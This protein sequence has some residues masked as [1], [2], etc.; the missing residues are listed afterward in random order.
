M[1]WL[2]DT[3]GLHA[4]ALQLRGKRSEILASNIA[5]AD[6]PGYKA[7][8][9]DFNTALAAA[10]SG[11]AGNALR[12]TDDQ[13]MSIAD[14]ARLALHYRIPTQDSSNGNTV[15]AEVEQAAF[16]QNAV[17]YQASAQFLD[18]AIKGLMLAIKGQ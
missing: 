13:H 8:D 2:D 5:N 18:G 9:M 7:R 11:A 4:Q 17:R 12:R 15:Q 14:S 16:A 10:R 1:G 6:T 3:M